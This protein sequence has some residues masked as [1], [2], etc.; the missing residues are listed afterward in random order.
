MGRDRGV[1]EVL[2]HWGRGLERRL[3]AGPGAWWPGTPRGSQG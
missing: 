3:G 2:G 1:V